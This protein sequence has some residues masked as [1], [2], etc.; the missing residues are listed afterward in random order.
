MSFMGLLIICDY[1]DKEFMTIG[2]PKIPLCPYCQGEMKTDV[3]VEYIPQGA[4]N[5]LGDS[6][7]D[8]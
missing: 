1:C 4:R 2:F 6:R 8:F 3:K 7:Y 5:F